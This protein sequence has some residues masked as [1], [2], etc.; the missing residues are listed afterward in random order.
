[1]L[2]AETAATW[3]VNQAPNYLVSKR[4]SRPSCP[5]NGKGSCAQEINLIKN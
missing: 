3:I 4:S 5:N 2:G 1:M